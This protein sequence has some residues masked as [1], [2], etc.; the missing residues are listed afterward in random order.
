MRQRPAPSAARTAISRSRTAARERRRLATFTHDIT[1]RRA[2]VASSASTRDWSCGETNHSLK[3]STSALHRSFE[4]GYSDESCVAIRRSASLAWAAVTPGV[5]RATPSMRRSLRGYSGTGTSGVH[6]S[7]RPGKSKSG[8]MTPT[9]RCVTPSSE[10]GAPSTSRDPP[11]RRAQSPSLI[12]ATRE[13]PPLRSSS[14][15]IVRPNAGATPNTG[16]KEAVTTAPCSCSDSPLTTRLV[17]RPSKPACV[18]R[19]PRATQ[20]R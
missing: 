7:T 19:V 12:T 17:R 1:R 18:M 3:G 15:R 20:S 16:K 14:G 5:R 6:T 13:S 10:I 8:G 11:K 4:T 9:I 2:T